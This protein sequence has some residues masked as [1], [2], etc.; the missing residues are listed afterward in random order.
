MCAFV[1]YGFPATL[2]V[3]F[4][5]IFLLDSMASSDLWRAFILN[6]SRQEVK[7]QVGIL[8]VT[9]SVQ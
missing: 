3:V 4:G 2:T 1:K 5:S 9:S 7:S 8:H 6:L